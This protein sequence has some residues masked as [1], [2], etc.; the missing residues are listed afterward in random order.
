MG[1]NDYALG[2]LEC[3][4]SYVHCGSCVLASSCPVYLVLS[5]ARDEVKRLTDWNTELLER[6]HNAEKQAYR[7]LA[8]PDYEEDDGEVRP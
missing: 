3:A 4:K 5:D 7:M 1:Y 2:D 6:A 8:Q